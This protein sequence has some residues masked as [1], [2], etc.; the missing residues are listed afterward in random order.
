MPR[1][2]AREDRQG[3]GLDKGALPNQIFSQSLTNKS[4]KEVD[5]T[6]RK[7]LDQKNSK[8][9]L[10]V[11]LNKIVQMRAHLMNYGEDRARPLAFFE[12]L[13]PYIFRR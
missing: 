8:M 2:E 9:N 1:D 10:A 7:L 13:K 4:D 5:D 12:Y 6:Y 11:S 3:G